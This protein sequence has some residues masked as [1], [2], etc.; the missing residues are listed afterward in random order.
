MYSDGIVWNL[1]R[2]LFLSVFVITM[3]SRENRWIYSVWPVWSMHV[4]SSVCDKIKTDPLI[5]HESSSLLYCRT[6]GCIT[7]AISTTTYV[8][9]LHQLRGQEYFW[10]EIYDQCISTELS[11]NGAKK[12]PNRQQ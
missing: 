2:V 5:A 11:L 9:F 4:Q 3:N 12:N 10:I 7:E 8:V 1:A 6:A